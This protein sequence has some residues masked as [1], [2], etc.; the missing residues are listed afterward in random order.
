M[1]RD[2]RVVVRS[3]SV[4]ELL[5]S[6]ELRDAMLDA[7]RPLVKGGA[8]AAPKLTGGGAASIRAEAVLDGPAWE[9]RVS[10]DRDHFYMYFHERGTK[11]LPARPFLVPTLEELAQ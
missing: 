10:W 9:V 1:A 4:E 3:A 11:F 6:P 8:A 2:V 7:A 5:R